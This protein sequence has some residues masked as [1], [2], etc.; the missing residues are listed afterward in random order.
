MVEKDLYDKTIEEVNFVM[1]MFDVDEVAKYDKRL[2]E[3][4]PA[5]FME[6]MH[7]YIR[8]QSVPDNLCTVA[9][10][11]LISRRNVGLMKRISKI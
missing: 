5:K 11:F 8:L 7:R 2:V 9:G 4:H 10:N 6:V 3:I 1:S